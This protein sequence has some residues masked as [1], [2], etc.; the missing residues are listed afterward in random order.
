[1]FSYKFDRIELNYHKYETG[2]EMIEKFQEFSRLYKNEVEE[3]YTGK[4][5]SSVLLE[6]EIPNELES[7]LNDKTIKGSVGQGN[8]TYYPWIGIFDKRVSTGATNGFYVVLLFSDDFEYLYL[9]LNQGST[10]QD[11]RTIE[12]N[13]DFVYDCLPEINGFEKGALPKKSLVR[14]DAHKP[15]NKGMKYEK[16]NLFYK[17]Y[18]ISEMNEKEFIEDLKRIVK[19]YDKCCAN[20]QI[21]S[22][23]S[24][25]KIN[26]SK[27]I[28]ID[29]FCDDINQANLRFPK[30]TIARFIASLITKPFLI[31]TGLAGSGKTKLAQAFVK[32]I[33][34]SQEQY[35]L[36]PV[37]SDWTNREPLLGYPNALD[38]GKYC[39]PDN[40]ILDVL[41]E[42]G[43]EE[44]C[45]KPYFI[46]LDEMNLSHVERYFADFLSAMESGEAI[47]LHNA[48]NAII[49]NVPEKLTIPDNV[50]VIG[51][52]NVDETTYM[53]SPKVLDRANVIEFIVTEEDLSEFINHPKKPEL[54][55]LEGLGSNMAASFVSLSGEE[56]NQFPNN[57]FLNEKL[58]AFFRTLKNEGSEFGYRTTYE[59]YRFFNIFKEIVENSQDE[60]ILDFAVLQKLLPKIHGSRKKLV[61]LLDVLAVLC[62]TN[63]AGQDILQVL[64]K[65]PDQIFSQNEVILKHSLEKILRMKKRVIQEGF[66]S[67]AEA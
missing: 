57:G 39:K 56:N 67:F 65:S 60:T 2:D 44:N 49:E 64:E 32:W 38:S 7:I 35:C 16:T 18:R 19:A 63:G 34:E 46:I 52:V 21:Y 29:E 36:V 58:P 54:Y 33:C 5:K 30:N 8:H 45:E 41:I 10:V 31:L 9:T 17:E 66:T 11:Q 62:L 25:T 42:A 53:F 3:P 20:Y 23:H 12:E 50:Y 13:T 47:P 24:K 1:V 61:P 48:N 55:Q 40:H 28:N 6:K 37:G 22:K 4:L 51:T 26:K 59:I 14:R 43:K 27:S 15:N